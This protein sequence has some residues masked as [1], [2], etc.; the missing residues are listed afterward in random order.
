MLDGMTC[1]ADR[2]VEIDS[3]VA[4]RRE[5]RLRGRTAVV[6][7]VG[8]TIGRA[9]ALAFADEGADVLAVDPDGAVASGVASE[10]RTAGGSGWAIAAALDTEDGAVAVAAGCRSRWQ[11]LDVLFTAHAML[12]HEPAGDAGLAHWE[13]VIRTNLLGPIAYTRALF[14]LLAESGS[15]AVIYLSSIDGLLGNPS[16]PSYSVS[17]GGLIPLT[18]VM[19]HDGAP[20]GIRVNAIAM[21]ALV[22]IG[23][24]DPEPLPIADGARDAVSRATP[25][26]R[27]ATPDDVAAAA[28]FLAS[29]ESGYITGVVLPVDGG[30]TAITPGTGTG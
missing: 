20:H 26:S 6:A 23:S 27:P 19:A 10:V 8:S 30:R 24:T 1:E 13:R 3:G 15:G 29:P 18:H 9:C 17:K 21:A 11:R 25:L 12:D 14:S 16:F 7:G 4:G 22:P 5:G 2:G 28:V